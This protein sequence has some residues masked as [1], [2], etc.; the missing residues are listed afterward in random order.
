MQELMPIIQGKADTGAV[1]YSDG[2]KTCGGLVNYGY[3]KHFRVQ[4]GQNEFADER[5][6]INGIEFFLGFVKFGSQSSEGCIST[7]STCI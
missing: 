1:S 5:H 2:F 7:C 3:K 4:H 6:H